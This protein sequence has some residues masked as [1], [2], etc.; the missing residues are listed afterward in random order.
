MFGIFLFK[1]MAVTKTTETLFYEND[2]TKTAAKLLFDYF[3][4]TVLILLNFEKL[5]V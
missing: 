4:S 5:N 3:E 2:G 1:I